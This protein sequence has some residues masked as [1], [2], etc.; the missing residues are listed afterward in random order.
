M[1]ELPGGPL[2]TAGQTSTIY[3]MAPGFSGRGDRIDWYRHR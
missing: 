3:L 1:I 2:R